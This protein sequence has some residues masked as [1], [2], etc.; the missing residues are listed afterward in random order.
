MADRTIDGSLSRW[1]G[2]QADGP[3]PAVLRCQRAVWGK[4]HAAASDYRWLALSEGFRPADALARSLLLPGLENQPRRVWFWRPHPAG[5]GY[6]AGVA[7][8]SRAKDAA[9]RQEFL[10]KQILVFDNPARRPAAECALLLLPLLADWNDSIWWDRQHEVDW[11]K[12][13]SVLDIACA[14]LAVEN[15]TQAIESAARQGLRA[16]RAQCAEPALARFYAQCLSRQRPACLHGLDAPLPPEALAALLLALDCGQADALSIAG[17]LPADDKSGQWDAVCLPG[18][19]P[20]KLGAD[21]GAVAQATRLAR[22][23]SQKN[24]SLLG[25]PPKTAQPPAAA[26]SRQTAGAV[27]RPG[28]RFRLRMPDPIMRG[29]RLL[30]AVYDFACAWDRRWLAPE[31]VQSAFGQNLAEA[32]APD[33]E[34]AQLL[35]EWIACLSRDRPWYAEG[36]DAKVDQL[37]ALALALSPYP[38]TLDRL[39]VPESVPPLLYAHWVDKPAVWFQGL[40]AK[41]MAELIHKS[42][43]HAAAKAWLEAWAS[44]WAAAVKT[45]PSR[46]S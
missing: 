28:M 23:L 21:A 45:K 20:A 15:L 46:P 5:Q 38:A 29:Y 19:P 33:S 3:V 10:E 44:Q 31:S 7:Y 39:G 35:Y 41:K 11:F 17:W 24:P 13:D 4:A 2:L 42:R 16:L 34:E 32:Y 26:P 36:W 1:P 14:P 43:G 40:D 8:P 9:G 30:L 18:P 6:I 22:A 27:I 25:P 12:P 37:R